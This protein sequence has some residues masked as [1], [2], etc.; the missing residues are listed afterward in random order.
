[1]K[2]KPSKYIKLAV[3]YVVMA[4]VY[5]YIIHPFL[6]D[7]APFLT[8]QPSDGFDRHS[9]GL[10]PFSLAATLVAGVFIYHIVIK[11]LIEDGVITLVAFFLLLALVLTPNKI[12]P[13]KYHP[14]TITQQDIENRL[15]SLIP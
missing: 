7:V 11:T 2:E 6:L 13:E 10:G 14:G 1:M 15:S 3:I 5:I 8:F 4:V 9:G 12:L